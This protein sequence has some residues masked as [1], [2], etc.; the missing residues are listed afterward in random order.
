MNC[1]EAR[2]LMHGFADRELGLESSLR[3]EAHLEGC[4]ACR[5]LLEDLEAARRSAATAMAYH[6]APPALEAGIRSRLRGGAAPRNFRTALL[7]APV[8]VL[9]LALGW[10]GGRHF[11]ADGAAVS[12][13]SSERVVFHISAADNARAALRN[14]ANHIDSAPGTRVVVVAHNS[15]VEFLL[16]GAR[17]GEGLA[18]QP[19]V[20]ELKRRGVD[21]RVCG[22]T[23]ALRG[24]GPA[25][26]IPEAVLVRSGIA[27][28]SRLQ[29]REGFAYLRL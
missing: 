6:R 28:I 14:L 13:A 1:D 26:V 20:A 7:A 24:I 10:L 22:N 27:E 18:Y 21:F 4:G 29:T 3:F 25:R 23:L 8:L 12:L 17:D 5:A 16:A 19:A 2:K 15:G 9:A 11:P